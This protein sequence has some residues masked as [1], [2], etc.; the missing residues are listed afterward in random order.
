MAKKVLEAIEAYS[1][2]RKDKIIILASKK[3]RQFVI[4]SID[5]Y[6]I[7]MEGLEIEKQFQFLTNKRVKEKI[8]FLKIIFAHKN[9]LDIGLQNC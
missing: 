6:Y 2:I 7:P 9:D 1:D 8:N 5:N 3:Y 4:G